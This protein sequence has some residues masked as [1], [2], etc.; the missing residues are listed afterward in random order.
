MKILP[1]IN[2]YLIIDTC[3]SKKL[4]KQCLVLVDSSNRIKSDLQKMHC[5]SQ[6][7]TKINLC[8]N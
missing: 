3:F 6:N 8:K 7:Q 4:A 5:W 2:N 1:K